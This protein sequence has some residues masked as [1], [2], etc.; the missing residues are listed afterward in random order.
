MTGQEKIYQMVTDRIIEELEKGTVPWHKPWLSGQFAPANLLSGRPYRGINIILTGMQGYECPYWLSFKQVN[1][2]GGR[3]KKDEKGTVII[4]WRWVEKKDKDAGEVIDTFPILR[5]YK[6]WN[7]EQCEGLDH[8]RITEWKKAQEEGNGNHVIERCEEIVSGMPNPPVIK[9]G[10]GRACYSPALDEVRMPKRETF[11]SSETVYSAEFH[12]LVHSTG[13]P[14]RLDRKDGM[15]ELGQPKSEY[16][17]EELV[18]E[19]GAAFLCNITGI[20][21]KVIENQA[22]YIQNWLGALKDDSK[23]VVAAAGRAQK[24]VDY[25]MKVEKGDPEQNGNGGSK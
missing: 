16:A 20:G 11:E 17:K 19:M 1:E 18:A 8:K 13:H 6:V 15:A 23:M 22:A 24:A 5:Y 7:V 2:L 12:E 25:M 9:W 14:D 10:G 21:Q 3:V 4:F